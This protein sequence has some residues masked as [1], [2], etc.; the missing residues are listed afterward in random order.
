MQTPCA[1]ATHPRAHL[2]AH[3][4]KAACIPLG[5]GHREDQRSL[6]RPPTWMEYI[7]Q[8]RLPHL[9]ADPSICEPNT[10]ADAT[11]RVQNNMTPAHVTH[12]NDPSLT[13]TSSPR[14]VRRLHCLCTQ[15]TVQPYTSMTIPATSM[16]ASN[17]TGTATCRAAAGRGEQDAGGGGG[18]VMSMAVDLPGA[19]ALRRGA[20]YVSRSV[21]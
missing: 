12:E 2:S 9:C 11:S 20:M 21:T 6:Q 13:H 4:D 14:T 3:A 10:C 16:K 18:P 19:V 1:V 8:R 17:I 5:I 15:T 7:P